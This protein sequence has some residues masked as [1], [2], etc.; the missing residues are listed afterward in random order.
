MFFKVSLRYKK[1]IE[2]FDPYYRLVESY[3]NALGEPRQRTILT[4]GCIEERDMPMDVVAERLNQ[5]LEGRKPLFLAEERVEKF[6]RKLFNRMISEKKIDLVKKIQEEAKKW[7]NV[8]LNTLTN[9]DVREVGAEWMGLQALQELGVDA[10]LHRQ[11]WEA[12]EVQLA[13]SH[14]VSRAVY[15]ASELKTVDFMRENSSICELSG[16]PI[17]KV[18]KDK[19][20]QISKKLYSEKEE[21]EKHLSKKTSELFDLQDKIILYDLTNTYFEGRM[22]GSKI[23]RFGRSKEKRSDCKLLVLALVVNVEGFIKYSTIF[24]GDMADCRT[25]EN[26][27]DKLRIATSETGQ[28]A[29]VV[30]DAGIA[31]VANL[32][33]LKAKGYDYVCV[34]RKKLTKYKVSQ[35]L[36]VIVKDKQEREI[37]LQEI[38]VEGGD[39]EYY[40][41]VA[42]PLKALKEE[43]MRNKFCERFETQLKNIESGIHKK[44]GV[45]NYGKVCERIGRLKEKYPS[46][47]RLYTIDIKKDTKD[48][49]TAIVWNLIPE[50]VIEKQEEQGVYFVKTSLKK[51]ENTETLV[52]TIYNSIRNIESSFRCLKTDLDLRPVYHKT[53][54]ASQAHLHLGLLAYWA[55]NTIRH[56]LKISGIHSEWREIVRTMNTQKLVTTTVENDKNQ[57]IKIRKCS[58]PNEKVRL[59]YAALNY[60][61]APYLQRKSVVPK[62]PDPKNK[63]TEFQR[64]RDG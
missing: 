60:K 33:L 7:D 11:G 16:Y 31:T 26:I 62:P 15:P 24:E 23:A 10:F 3:R 63:T 47:T 2:D 42:S 44:S 36:P 4:V 13:L 46:V 58:Q 61:L 55:V 39:S 5:M 8:D 41:K 54:D 25:V 9:E 35:T 6:A 30:M 50:T 27:I 49:C 52:W 14:I 37:T 48:N 21:L 38:E 12:E 20:Y 40:L 18:T 32:A 59:I 57:I 34:S 43:A 51:R 1:E 22:E 56:K 28:K 53:D 19:L 17:K 45:K 64:F 29:V